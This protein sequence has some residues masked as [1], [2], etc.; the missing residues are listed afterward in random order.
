MISNNKNLEI[1]LW[2]FYALIIL[3]KLHKR[4]TTKLI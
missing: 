1:I 4:A 2:D 3:V